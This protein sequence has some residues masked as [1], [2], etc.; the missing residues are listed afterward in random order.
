MPSDGVTQGVGDGGDARAVAAHAHTGFGDLDFRGG[1]PAGDLDSFVGFFGGHHGDRHVY[2]HV[3]AARN[4]RE[5]ARRFEG[6]GQPAR[7]FDVVVVPE[8]GGF[9]PPCMSMEKE[10]FAASH[11]TEARGHRYLVHQDVVDAFEDVTRLAAQ[12]AHGDA[13]ERGLLR[14]VHQTLL[15]CR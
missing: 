9:A 14:C 4:R 15:T 2:G 10:S 5:A 8:G 1:A 12:R 7:G 6:G 13:H 3:L 11:A